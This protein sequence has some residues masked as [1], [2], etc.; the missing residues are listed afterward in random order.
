MSSFGHLELGDPDFSGQNGTMP[1]GTS[2]D[3]AGH[4]PDQCWT[5]RVDAEMSWQG[6][7]KGEKSLIPD[8]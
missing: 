8:H 3:M 7:H 1:A 6:Q 2:A 5:D 4:S